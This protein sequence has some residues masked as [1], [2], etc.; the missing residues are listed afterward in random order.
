MLFCFN[1]RNHSPGVINIQRREAELIIILPRVN[2]FEKEP[3]L[4]KI[5]RNKKFVTIVLAISAVH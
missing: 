1:I 4:S 2:N 5:H 3:K